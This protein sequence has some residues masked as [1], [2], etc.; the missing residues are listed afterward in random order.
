MFLSSSGAS[1]EWT[2]SVCNSVY[3]RVYA[4]IS[5]MLLLTSCYY[6]VFYYVFYHIYIANFICFVLFCFVFMV[7]II[8]HLITTLLFY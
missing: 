8:V 2:C 5:Y 4:C 6:E 7:F 1:Q 3:T